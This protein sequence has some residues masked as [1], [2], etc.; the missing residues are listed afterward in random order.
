MSPI[1]IS[2]MH[3][4][5]NPTWQYIDMNASLKQHATFS[6]HE[7]QFLLSST[8]SKWWTRN[9]SESVALLLIARRWSLWKRLLEFNFFYGLV[10]INQSRSKKCAIC[11]FIRAN[12]VVSLTWKLKHIYILSIA[13][14]KCVPRNRHHRC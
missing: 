13:L 4:C 14:K 9:I 10:K 3:D 1:V 2:C 12:K 8:L 6:S 11:T 7:F 5:C